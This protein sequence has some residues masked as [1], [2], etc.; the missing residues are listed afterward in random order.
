MIVSCLDTTV[1]CLEM[2]V[3]CFDTKHSVDI[4]YKCD[5]RQAQSPHKILTHQPPLPLNNLKN[6]AFIDNLHN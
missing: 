2:I 3:S 6:H 1:L 4:L 5:V